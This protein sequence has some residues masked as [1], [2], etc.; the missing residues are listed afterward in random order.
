MKLLFCYNCEDVRKLQQEMVYCS[1]GKSWGR[2]KKDKLN[3]EYG[4]IA[5]PIGFDNNSFVLAYCQE[6][7]KSNIFTAFFIPTTAETISF[8]KEK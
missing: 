2:Y 7:T 6:R 5:I 8:I 4:G 3:A 1:C